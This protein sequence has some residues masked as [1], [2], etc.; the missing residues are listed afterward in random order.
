MC[1][2]TFQD[3]KHDVVLLNIVKL[4]NLKR[5]QEFMLYMTIFAFNRQCRFSL[6]LLTSGLYS[7]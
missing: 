5:L 7:P 2:S 1:H 3:I 4:I 6:I